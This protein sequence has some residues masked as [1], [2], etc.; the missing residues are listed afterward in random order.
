MKA[1]Q[2][3]L[4]NALHME[5]LKKKNYTGDSQLSI[6]E[7]LVYGAPMLCDELQIHKYPF[8]NLEKAHNVM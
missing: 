5:D 8:Y 7:F 3:H 6:F 4:C 1:L 2:S